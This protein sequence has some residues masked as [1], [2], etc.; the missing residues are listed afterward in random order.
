[1]EK[2]YAGG[3]QMKRQQRANGLAIARDYDRIN[4]IIGSMPFSDA[5][6]IRISD[7]LLTPEI[8][9][10]NMPSI[11]A[12][13]TVLWPFLQSLDYYRDIACIT[14]DQS[15][16]PVSVL[17]LVEYWRA[18]GYLEN[19]RSID[20]SQFFAQECTNDF[21]WI[22]CDKALLKTPWFSRVE[23][24]IENWHLEMH[25]KILYITYE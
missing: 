21:L 13:R 17:S 19:E 2:G 12:A 24:E 16:L 15:P 3:G 20:F 22:E 8:R 14:L 1:M 7:M 25:M 6:I 18:T 9:T 23:E 4:T 5:E 10:W 11:A